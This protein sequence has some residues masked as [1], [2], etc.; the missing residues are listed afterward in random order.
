MVVDHGLG[1]SVALL[2]SRDHVDVCLDRPRR[3]I[4]VEGVAGSYLIER[5]LREK[6]GSFGRVYLASY[7]YSTTYAHHR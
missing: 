6:S 3:A 4:A 1:V 7:V 5:I 2:L